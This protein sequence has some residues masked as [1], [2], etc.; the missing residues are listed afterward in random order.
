MPCAIPQKLVELV[1]W[2]NPQVVES[3]CCVEES[4]TLEGAGLYVFRKFAGLNPVPDLFRFLVC[5]ALQ[6][7]QHIT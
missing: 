2:W 1:A 6:H 3:G 5:E 4:Q 7:L